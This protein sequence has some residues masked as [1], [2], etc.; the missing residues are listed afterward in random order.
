MATVKSVSVVEVNLAIS[1]G[2]Q[3]D[4]AVYGTAAPPVV[5]M[6][7]DV[8]GDGIYIM[9]GTQTAVTL[10][11]ILDLTNAYHG[12]NITVKRGTQG[13]TTSIVSVVSGSA[14]GVVVSQLTSGVSDEVLAVFDGPSNVWR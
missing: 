8:A 2:V 9:A 1:Q 3:F 6:G 7:R 10:P 14:A 11:V 4:T 12:A 5:R 13:M